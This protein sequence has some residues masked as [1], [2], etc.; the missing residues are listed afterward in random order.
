MLSIGII[1]LPNVGKSTL[2]NALL[3]R[4]LALVA[5]HPFT[6]IDKNTGVVSVPDRRLNRLK[7]IGAELA[8][9]KPD[10]VEMTPTAIKFVD[11]A[12]LVKGAHQGE[13]LGN[14]FLGHIREV[15]ALVHVLRSFDS[16][17]P[18]VMGDVDPLQD[19]GIVETEMILKDLETVE[20]I[21][22]EK[23]KT[24]RLD[25]PARRARREN[26]NVKLKNLINRIKAELDDGVMVKNQKLTEREREEIKELFLLTD[27]PMLYVLNVS[28]DQLTVHGGKATISNLDL[29]KKLKEK[30]GNFLVISAKLESELHH[31]SEDEAQDYIADFGIKKSSL[32]QI[33]V[34]SYKILDLLTFFTIAK[35]KKVNAW[36]LEKGKTVI[37]AAGRVHSDFARGFIKAEVISYHNLARTSSWSKAAKI[38]KI[39]LVGKDY[40]VNEGDVIEFKFSV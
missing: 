21:K 15:D 5:R 35:G 23:L 8:K 39:N 27:K 6:T 20:K 18:H 24:T 1:G 33:V 29:A 19:L 13:G 10:Q 34:E 37:E 26:D 3:G 40:Q 32:D 25:E 22:N 9:I 4:E 16:G 17:V 14:E 28:E 11:I 7:T 31:L 12:G 36:A 30:A 2:F 38:G